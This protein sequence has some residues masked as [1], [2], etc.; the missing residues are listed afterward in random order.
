V[1]PELLF[2]ISFQASHSLENYEVEH[3]HL[4]KLEVGFRGDF[5][6]DKILDIPFARGEIQKLVD[7]LAGS[8]L[9]QNEALPKTAQSFPTCETLGQHFLNALDKL[10]REKFIPL[11]PSVTLSQ[12]SVAIC[13]LDGTETGAVRFSAGH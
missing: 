4:W 13:D 10:N 1:K 6:R 11:N 2:K 3:A 9:N 12:V 7:A 5:I 8:F